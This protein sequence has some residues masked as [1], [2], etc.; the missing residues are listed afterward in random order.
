MF[1]SGKPVSTF[2]I[3]S[4]DIPWCQP[5][6]ERLFQLSSNKTSVKTELIAGATTFIATMYIVIVN[7]MI[8][9][10]AGMR[11]EAVLTAT[12]IVCVFS[13][14]MMG[15]YAN[16]PIVVAPGMG[17]NAFFTY[18][19]V[20]GQGIAVDIALGA[21]FWSGMI[22]LLLSVLRIRTYILKAIPASVRYGS[23]AGIGLFIALIGF[24]NAGF[25]TAKTPLIGLGE[26]NSLTITFALGVFITSLL[27][28]ARVQGALLLGVMITTLLAYPIGRWYGDA[29]AVNFGN[30]V[31]VEPGEFISMPDFSYIFNLKLVE[32]LQL[33]ILPAAFGLLFTDMFDSISTF[34]GVA[35][36]GDLKQQNGDPRNIEKS[37]I[38]D[39]F[40]TIIA[41]LSGSSP[42]TAYIESASGIQAGGRTGLTA[43]FAGILFIPLLFFAPVIKI[44]PAIATA[45]VLVIV[46]VYM[47][48]ACTKIAWDDFSDAIPAFLS[49]I[50]IPLT[51]SITQGLIWGLLMYTF[52]KAVK[53]QF[54][55]I[56][57]TLLIINLFSMLL[58]W[59]EAQ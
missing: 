20:L 12:I 11:Y 5:V 40:A 56:P 59:L 58:L 44:V 9:S 8:L 49:L 47:M 28:I 15:V 57:K 39:S 4:F 43:V 23:A 50:L 51:Y 17:I 38:A 42:G 3:N 46:G 30:P 33:A 13:S 31:L 21:V 55:A 6:L 36:A 37:M 52:L 10:Q 53:G 22:F 54:N 25:I 14:I 27:V 26:M 1:Y 34:V 48:G 45:P 35:E 24:V 29:S 16:N 32:S 2:T 19:I 18:S 41:G 7:P